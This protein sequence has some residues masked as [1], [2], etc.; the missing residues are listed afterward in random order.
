MDSSCVMMEQWRCGW[1]AD[2]QQGPF[3]IS[4]VFL[5]SHVGPR[6]KAEGTALPINGHHPVDIGAPEQ[7]ARS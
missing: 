2:L 1:V 7:P 6:A 3:N 5:I 4:S